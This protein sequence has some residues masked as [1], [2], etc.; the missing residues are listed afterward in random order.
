MPKPHIPRPVENYTNAF[1]TMCWVIL[2]MGL[3]VIHA[4]AGAI[5]VAIT[6]AAVD[7]T[8]T[9]IGRLRG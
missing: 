6:A 9:L 4:V 2:F 1:L 5:W 3:W 7:R 8:I